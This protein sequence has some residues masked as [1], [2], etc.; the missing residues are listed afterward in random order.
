MIKANKSLIFIR[1]EISLL[2]VNTFLKHCIFF[3]SLHVRGGRATLENPPKN[4]KRPTS[5]L[6]PPALQVS[7][8]LQKFLRIF[9]AE[10]KFEPRL[11]LFSYVK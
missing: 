8:F 6:K 10:F 5:K 2:L 1:V 9:C 11:R 3:I 4:V 7:A